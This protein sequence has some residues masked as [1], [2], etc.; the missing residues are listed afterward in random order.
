MRSVALSAPASVLDVDCHGNLRVVVR[1]E[2]H[3]GGVI[4]AV[5]VLGGACLSAHFYSG[6]GGAAA[7]AAGHCHAHA[8]GNVFVVV[9]L[10]GRTMYL[11]H[12]LRKDGVLYFLDDMRGDEISAV[13]DGGAEIGN[14]ERGRENLALPDGY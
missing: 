4:V 10:D 13:G 8:F 7:C 5:R 1:R 3:E 2:A 9:T 12:I 11:E 14:L 6:Y